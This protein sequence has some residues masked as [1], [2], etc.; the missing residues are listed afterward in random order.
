M[1]LCSRGI[2]TT[3]SRNR[4]FSTQT[5]QTSPPSFV[6]TCI[7]TWLPQRVSSLSVVTIGDRKGCKTMSQQYMAD[8]R[9]RCKR[10]P[11]VRGYRI[12]AWYQGQY[13]GSD[14]PTLWIAEPSLPPEWETTKNNPNVTRAIL[15]RSGKKYDQFNRHG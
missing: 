10:A 8:W 9:I 6:Q 15:F 13:V 14:T 4:T 5:A 7:G 3:S 12:R 1:Y 11:R 2:R